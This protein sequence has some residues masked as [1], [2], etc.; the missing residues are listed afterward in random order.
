MEQI[1]ALNQTSILD[2]SD[3]GVT[4]ATDAA[5]FADQMVMETL[6]SKYQAVACI[7][8][9]CVEA[10]FPAVMAD[11]GIHV[12]FGLDLLT[13]M[14]L[15]KRADVPTLIGLLM[16]HFVDQD[17]E[18]NKIWDPAQAC[19]DEL[20]KMAAAELVS[21]DDT[22]EVFILAY[23]IS[24]DVQNQIDILQYPLPMIQEPVKV[25]HN[26]Q[27]GYLSIP[28]SIILKKNHH[29][30]DVCLD[31]INRCNQ[32]PLTLNPDVVNYVQNKWKNHNTQKDDESFEKFQK[33]CKAFKKYDQSS[34]DVLEALRV[35]GNRFWL[36]HKYDKRGRTY[37]QGYAVTYQGNDFNK[38]CVEFA[39]AEITELETA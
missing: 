17:E 19:A 16:K 23:G 7:K 38:A 18:I 13:Q 24:E 6:F 31:H 27:T 10:N 9:E 22:A 15:H 28:G 33:R 3:E 32:V 14:V 25:T 21:W 8:R 37:C 29:D 26:K 5:Y 36:T 35:A 11:L 20:Y 34:H 4:N 30:D 39:D 1:M 2:N 12:E